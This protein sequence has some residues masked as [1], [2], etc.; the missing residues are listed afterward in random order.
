MKNKYLTEKERYNIEIYLEEKYTVRQI[1]EKLE[2]CVKTIYNEIKRG[3]VEFLD[4]ELRTYKKYCADVAQRKTNEA[5]LNKGKDLKIGNDMAFVHYVEEM[6]GNRRYSPVATLAEIKLKSYEFQTQVC[7]K[8]LYNYIDRGMFLNISNKDLPVKKSPCKRPYKR[9]SV[10]LNNRRGRSIEER[11]EAV[12]TRDSVGNWEMDTVVGGAGKSK[13]C[14]LVLTERMTRKELIRK[15][16]DKSMKSVVDALNDIERLYGFEEF[17][18]TFKTIT[19]DNGSEFFDSVGIE[20]SVLYPD[21]KRTVLYYCHPYNACERGSNENANKLIR[22]HIPKGCDI[23][24]YTDEQIQ[25]IENWINNYPRRILEYLTSNLV[26][27][28]V[29]GVK[30]GCLGG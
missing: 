11:P 19:S 27:E 8:T 22:R 21:K 13:S 28:K 15:I 2:R 24:D 6:I 4:S 20:T 10:A 17:K 18:N 3:T 30:C 9:V 23:G 16:P 12:K 25:E 14:L 1:A 29:L 5:Q 7:Y 26:Y